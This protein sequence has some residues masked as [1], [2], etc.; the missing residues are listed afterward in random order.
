MAAA[1]PGPH[2]G[3]SPSP[4]RSARLVSARRAAALCGETP[5]LAPERDGCALLPAARAVPV[6]VDVAMALQRAR[7]SE[8]YGQ[9]Y[10]CL[11]HAVF[12]AGELPPRARRPAAA[13]TLSALAARAP[14]P[15]AGAP[16]VPRAAAPH[17]LPCVTREAGQDGFCSVRIPRT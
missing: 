6:Q 9:S 14:V 2:L 11:L 10:V 8:K 12:V 4:A 1:G 3:A 13:H 17:P 16:L 5:G 7:L 15:A